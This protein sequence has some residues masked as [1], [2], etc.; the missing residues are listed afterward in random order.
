LQTTL[1][2]DIPAVHGDHA[3]C[4]LATGDPRDGLW[5]IGRIELLT[6]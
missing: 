3:L 5:A 1:T 2:A 4:I 6:Q